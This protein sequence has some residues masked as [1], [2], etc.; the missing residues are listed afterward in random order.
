MVAEWVY[1]ICVRES[2]LDAGIVIISPI[3]ARRKVVNMVTCIGNGVLIRRRQEE[4]PNYVSTFSGE[5]QYFI[6]GKTFKFKEV[7]MS[8]QN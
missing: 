2:T 1:Y 7:K 8:I 4:Q 5:D 3:Q 6:F